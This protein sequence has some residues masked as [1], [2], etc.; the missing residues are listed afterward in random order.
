MQVVL[1]SSNNKGF[2]EVDI[3]PNPLRSEFIKKELTDGNIFKIPKMPG[4]G[5]LRIPNA[6]KKYIQTSERSK[7]N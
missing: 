4:L 2:L 3:N 7:I 1:S 6:I 5:I